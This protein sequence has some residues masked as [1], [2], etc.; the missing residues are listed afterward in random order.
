MVIHRLSS[1]RLLYFKLHRR[2]NSLIHLPPLNY[3]IYETD[4]TNICSAFNNIINGAYHVCVFIYIK[5]FLS[6]INQCAH[7]ILIWYLK[8]FP[9]SYS[10]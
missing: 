10:L 6:V 1:L 4:S 3:F 8:F 5:S 9:K 7:V 2:F